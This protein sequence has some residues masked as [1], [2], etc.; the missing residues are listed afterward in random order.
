MCLVGIVTEGLNLFSIF[1]PGNLEL[2]NCKAENTLLYYLQS[3]S[4]GQFIAD[5]WDFQV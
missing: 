3:F 4:L 5:M 2:I 1:I